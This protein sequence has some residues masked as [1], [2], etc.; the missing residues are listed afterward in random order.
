M[1]L[2]SIKDSSKNKNLHLTI[3]AT[4]YLCIVRNAGYQ[5]PLALPTYLKS[6]QIISILCNN[7]FSTTCFL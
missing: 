2:N 4:A 3:D 5:D 7:R 1:N 6:M